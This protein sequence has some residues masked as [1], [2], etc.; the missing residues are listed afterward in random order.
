MRDGQHD[1]LEEEL[2][3]TRAENKK[4]AAALSAMCENY[5][6]LQNRLLDFM[7]LPWKRMKSDHRE[8]TCGGSSEVVEYH[9]ASVPKRHREIRT[10]ISRVHVHTDPSDTSLVR[11]LFTFLHPI[12]SITLKTHPSPM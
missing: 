10:N 9:E 6:S 4:L 8:T 3:E 12:V 11:Y 1:T 2:N 5:S 7:P